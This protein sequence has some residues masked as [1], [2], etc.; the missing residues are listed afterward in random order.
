MIEGLLLFKIL[1]NV[2]FYQTGN[3]SLYF[4]IINTDN[5]LRK[6]NRIYYEKEIKVNDLIYLNENI[7]R[8]IKVLRLKVQEK[9]ILFNGNGREF[10]SKI[11]KI[12]KKSVLVNIESYKKINNELSFSITLV[13]VLPEG[14]KMDFIIEKA[15]ELG[16]D[17]IQPLISDRSVKKIDQNRIKKKMNHWN[18]I[19]CSA[20]E[21]SGRNKLVKI[22][23]PKPF[24]KWIDEN[25]K[26]KLSYFQ[27][28]ARQN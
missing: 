6:M 16:V 17:N 9:I 22:F 10:V 1:I 26:K 15:V 13:Q 11:I 4:N 28:Q 27:I 18:N 19:I 25:K 20:S 23:E 21:Q 8:H 7:S 2:I 24:L 12:E 14:S 3:K 5:I